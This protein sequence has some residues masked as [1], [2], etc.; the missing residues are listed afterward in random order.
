MLR[1]K[2]HLAENKYYWIAFVLTLLM[3][4]PTDRSVI[5]RYCICSISCSVILFSLIKLDSN[6]ISNFVKRNTKQSI[7][8]VLF[9][10]AHAVILANSFNIMWRPSNK[11]EVLASH[12]R[13]NSVQFLRIITLL[14][15]P[16]MV[17]SLFVILSYL[18]NWYQRNHSHISEFVTVFF[19]ATMVF[20]ISQGISCGYVSNTGLKNM[21]C[22]IL[23]IIAVIGLVYIL[24]ASV[25]ISVLVGTVPFLLFS[26]VNFYVFA[27]RGRE[28]CPSDLFSIRTAINVVSDYK[29]FFSLVVMMGWLGW[30]ALMGAFF[31]T[32]READYN[33]KRTR[34]YSSV[35]CLLSVLLVFGLEKDTSVKSWFNSG[36]A[37]N[38]TMLNFFL[39]IRDSRV[40]APDDYSPDSIRQLEQRYQSQESIINDRQ[41]SIIVIMEESLTDF[42]VL[43]NE[44]QTEIPLLP[45]IS[46]LEEN[47][48]SGYAYSSV[49]GGNTANS[50]FE[51]LTGNSMAFLP[52]GSVPY[53]QYLSDN[54]YSLLSFLH[55]ENYNCIVTHPYI[56]NGWNRLNV[57]NWF[58]FDEMSFI[59]DYP[60]TERIRKYI[61]DRDMFEYIIN[62]YEKRDK[63]KGFFVFGITIQ[64]HGGYSYSRF[65]STVPLEYKKHYPEAEQ[66][67]SLA[68]LS[69]QAVEYLISYFS[70]VSDPVVICV[71]GD[72]QPRV[73][74]EFLEAVHGGAF[75]DLDSE[76]LKY[77][78][79]FFIWANYDIEEKRDVET[80]INYLST[81]LLDV[82][83]FEL[84]SYNK[85]LY[86]VEQHIPILTA[87]GYYSM[88]NNRFLPVS[89]ATGDEKEIL[90]LYHI[91]EYNSMFD[92]EQ[93]SRFFKTG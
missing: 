5:V 32:G 54:Q 89:E 9:S 6:Y 22:G 48:V 73:E 26:T 44:V 83:G 15:F 86:D 36:S 81:H 77:K 42:S 49:Y 58:G 75:D 41:P 37:I 57:Y 14:A 7:F 71:F 46:S 3:M 34:A 56:A 70:E 21:F 93:G 78:V 91:M 4:A 11:L 35:I 74:L 87:N 62:S 16:C 59:G 1:K 79:P 69:D 38:G 65:E 2:I 13:L 61:G 92:K 31:L 52:Y 84:P 64:N 28:I 17:C 53:Q 63:N 18:L 27:F 33:K 43:G 68:N 30:T 82:C 67:L 8:I 88:S 25:K 39:Q 12:F 60:Q 24:L 45:F 10:I 55:T 23:I 90:N 29:I 50:E 72:H 51:F 80:S 40:H 85:F 19:L 76:M 20:Q 47:A 66:Y